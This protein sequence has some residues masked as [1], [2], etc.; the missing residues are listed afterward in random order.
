MAED[1]TAAAPD[2][3]V[4]RPP[5]AETADPQGAWSDLV[6][7]VERG[8]EAMRRREMKRKGGGLRALDDDGRE[9]VERLTRDLL[10]R[11]VLERLWTV[12]RA[13]RRITAGDMRDIRDMFARS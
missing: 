5:M 4:D 3:C 9:V 2:L 13:R 11:A 12:F 10:R 7:E 6:A 1:T 8:L